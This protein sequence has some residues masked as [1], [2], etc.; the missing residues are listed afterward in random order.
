MDNLAPVLATGIVFLAIY[1]VFELFVRR[2]ERMAMIE[3]LS[4][5]IDPQILRQQFKA[6][7]YNNSNFNFWSI[8]IGLLLLGIGLGLAIATIM[9]LYAVSQAGDGFSIDREFRNTTAILYPALSAVFGGIGL[10]IAYFVERKDARKNRSL[11]D[12]E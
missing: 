10:V 3:K 11:D 7:L 9:D 6:P 2:G 5:G 4:S 1:K 12:K 8:R